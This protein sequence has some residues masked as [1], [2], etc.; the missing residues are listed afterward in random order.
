MA[1][2]TAALVK[3]LREKTGA[4]MMDCKKALNEANGEIEGAIDWL[5][6]KGLAAAAKKSG[7]TAAEGLVGVASEDKKAAMVEV[8]A[9]TDFVARNEAFQNF[10]EAVAKVALKTGEDLEAIKAATLESGRTVADELTHLIAT[11]G[12]NMSLRRARVFTVPSGVVATYV[13]GALRPGLGK[14]GVLAAIEAPTADD[15]IENLGRQVGMHV[16]ATR[17]SSLDVSSLNPE[18]VERER[19]VLIEQARASGKPEAIIEK[20]IEGRIR[21]FY[22]EVVLLEQVWVHDG[23]TR[24]K[25]VLE[26]AGVKLV[27]FDRFHL[28]EGIEKEADDFAA[29]VA[30]VSGV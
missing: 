21:K 19:A 16:A 23:E 11:I 20:M 24:V 2:I 28:G 6:T 3:E 4:G 27:G 10:V 13:H 12:E 26:K 30:K 14:I 17:P 5:R 29:E 9:E 1:A 7:R 18:E 22:E 8:N 25:S 15:A